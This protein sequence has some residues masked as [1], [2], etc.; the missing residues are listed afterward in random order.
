MQSL[1]FTDLRR[2]REGPA[3]LNSSSKKALEV[4][5]DVAG[6]K[7]V[8]SKTIQLKLDQRGLIQLSFKEGGQLPELLTGRFTNIEEVA[9]SLS[10]W[11]DRRAK[12]FKLDPDI[13]RPHAGGGQSVVDAVKD[14]VQDAPPTFEGAEPTAFDGDAD[15]DDDIEVALN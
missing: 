3:E 10:V 1:K 14:A 11:Q 9:T 5:I 15:D 6:P 13:Q 8:E 7:E 4:V 12:Q 2:D